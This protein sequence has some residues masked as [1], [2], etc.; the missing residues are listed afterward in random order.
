MTAAR[1]AEPPTEALPED[2]TRLAALHGVATAYRPSPDRQVPASATAVVRALAALGVD[3]GDPEAVR[4]A[5][6]AREAELRARLLPPTVVQWSGGDPPAALAALPVGTRLT[7]ETEQ[8]ETRS[9]PEGLPPGVHRLTATAPDGRA[10]EA[11]LVVAPRRL[12]TPAARSYGLLVQLYSLLSRRSWGMGD[13]GD[14]GEL[15]DWAGR[16]L[17]AGFVQVNPLHAAVPGTPTDPSPY[18]PSSRRFPD[19]VHLRIEDVPE[20]AY[21][22]DRER[23]APLL[24]R[25]ARL[26]ADVLERDALIDRD[27]VWEA[28]RA[29]LEV[30]HELP[31]QPGRAAAYRDY[32]AEQGAPLTD[33][34]T[35]CALAEVHGSDWRLWPEGL[36]DPRSAETARARAELAARIDFHARLAWLTDTQLAAAQRAARAAGMPVG[37]VHDLAVGVHPQGADAWAQQEYFAAGISVGAPPDAFN[38][39]GQDWGLPPWRPDRL[40]ESGYAPFRR[41]L[42]ALFHYAGALRIDHVMGL[43]RLW[44]VP[45][46]H[47][48]TEGTYVH[49]DAD[50]ML[51][52]LVLEASRAG[53]LVIGED[54]GTVEPGVREAL[55]ERGVLGTSVLWFERDWTGDGAPLP[56]ERWRAD[57]L[58]TATTH[59]LPSTAARLTGEHVTLRDSLGLLTRPLDVERA[60]AAADTKEWLA[61][62]DRLGLLAA[63]DHP[64]GTAEQAEEAEIQAV[65]R[66]LLRTPA[67]LTGIWLPD[68]VGDRRPQ[69]LPGTWDQYPNWRLPI[70]DARGRPVTLEELAAAPRVRALIDAVR[71]GPPA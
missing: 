23:L 51:A 64:A 28:K 57:C 29:A 46:G 20:Y 56:P 62:L 49:Y 61:F 67:R 47:P 42:R 1:P 13:L 34:A 32:L 44:W 2:L 16:T 55:R 52:V 30:L 9:A 40:A 25:G 54:L 53:A 68:T 5:L 36:R 6:A 19:P 58:A 63:P 70:A 3:A 35:W 50:A 60:E 8:G 43:F 17:G 69:N 4:S 39:L 11:H 65:H 48:P 31:L 27:A 33:H 15:A 10:A 7:I 22:Q 37:L 14:L 24:E 71:T 21:T 26:R 12:P 18:R 59:D 41:L 66:F 45:E 38:A